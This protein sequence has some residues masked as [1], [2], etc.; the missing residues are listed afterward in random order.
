MIMPQETSMLTGVRVDV[1]VGH[2]KLNFL[3]ALSGLFVCF[4]GPDS[5]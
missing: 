1:L 5:I 2:P 4:P 3:L